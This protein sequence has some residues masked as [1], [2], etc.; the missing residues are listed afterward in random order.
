MGAEVRVLK[1][2]LLRRAVIDSKVA[3][4]KIIFSFMYVLFSLH[5]CSM[6]Q[7]PN[8]LQLPFYL[9]KPDQQRKDLLSEDIL[10][11]A[12]FAATSSNQLQTL[13]SYFD[14]HQIFSESLIVVTFSRLMQTLQLLLHTSPSTCCTLQQDDDT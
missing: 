4:I 8:T 7:T 3:P 6:F 14:S 1:S 10:S 5:G 2:L 11:L 13:Q 12:L 9:Y